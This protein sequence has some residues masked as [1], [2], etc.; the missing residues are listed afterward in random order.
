MTWLRN[1][2]SGMSLGLITAV[3]IA[4]T[5]SAGAAALPDHVSMN[6]KATLEGPITTGAI[7]EPESALP[8]GVAQ[9]DYVETEYFASGTATAFKAT[10]T[11]NDGKWTVKPTT[12]APYKTRIIVRRPADPAK[13]NGTVVVEWMNV[14]SG[15]S[16]PDWDL[17]NPMLMDEG[18]AYVAVSA[19][20]LGVD[21]GKSLIQTSS[22]PATGLVQNNPARYASLLHPGDQYSYDIYAQIGQALHGSHVAALGGLTP[23]HVVAVGE[24]QSAAFLTTYAD[25]IQPKIAAYDGIFIHSRGGGGV[26]LNGDLTAGTGSDDLHIRSDLKVP[27]FMFETETD[28]TTLGYA[29]ARQPN[30]NKIRT[31]EVAG[32]SH[33]D[34]YIVGGYASQLGCTSP[35]NSGPQ[36]EVVQS[37]FVAFNNWV[38]KGTLP[39]V[40]S[41]IEMTSSKASPFVLDRWGNVKGGIRTPAVDVPTST[42]SG[43]APKGSTVICSLFGS[44]TTFTPSQLVA[45][46]GTKA[47][48]PKEYT[49]SL[50]KA[51]AAG[52]ILNADRAALL[53]QAQAVQFPAT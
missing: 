50:D 11:A 15:E 6:A 28:L 30:T 31:W 49:K 40:R 26:P 44:T 35:I 33:A 17:L 37:A 2:R 32:T 22:T 41:R 3:V 25:A 24:S 51:I 21:G 36:H 20:K 4:L 12:A 18:F 34:T 23:K 7:T 46:Y 43:L 53:K 1:A 8:T 16:S 42:L 39:P 48:Y 52:F 14:T 29:P 45:R 13:F 47:G 38:T 10:S 27:V 19:Q 9:H 5:S